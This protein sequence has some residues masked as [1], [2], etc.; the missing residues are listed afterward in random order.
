MSS[1]YG[2][3]GGGEGVMVIQNLGESEGSYSKKMNSDFRG[4]WLFRIGGERGGGTISSGPPLHFSKWNS[5]M[6]KQ[7]TCNAKWVKL[8]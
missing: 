3:G 5:P 7:Y 6:A 4:A 2:G 1:E 8:F